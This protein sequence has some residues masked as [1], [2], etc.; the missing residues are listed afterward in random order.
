MRTHN[1]ASE[2][3]LLLAEFMGGSIVSREPYEMPHGSRSEG[4]IEKWGGLTG[5]PSGDYELACI[6]IFKYDSK[7][8][9]IWPVINK[10]ESLGFDFVISRR[11]IQVTKWRSRG[12]FEATDLII[13]E[14]FQD[15]YIGEEKRIAVWDSAVSFVNWYNK[16]KS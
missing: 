16:Q 14:D 2:G 1:K 15:D 10:I 9:W 7:W 8:E 13:D 12:R 3:N 4:V 6:G 5:V 11:G